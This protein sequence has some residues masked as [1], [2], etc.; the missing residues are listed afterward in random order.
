ME[1]FKTQANTINGGLSIISNREDIYD[2][3]AVKIISQDRENNKLFNPINSEII[4][5]PKLFDAIQAA[6]GITE[7]SDL[8]QVEIIRIDTLSNGGGFK[9]TKINFTNSLEKEKTTSNIR[10]FDGDTIIVK[11]LDKKNENLLEK[12]ILARLN[13][14]FV[15]VYV[16]GR[17][18][19]RTNNFT[20]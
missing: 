9:K 1:K 6:N 5:F 18:E 19:S 8:S 10:I 2:Q 15:N 3:G 14:K 20:Y 16:A 4:F 13:P 12:S 7:F 17:V 11:R